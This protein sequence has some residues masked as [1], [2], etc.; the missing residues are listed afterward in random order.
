MSRG[1]GSGYDRWVAPGGVISAGS[2][3]GEGPAG[4]GTPRS[5][6]GLARMRMRAQ[7]SRRPGPAHRRTRC[8]HPRRHITIFSPEGRLFQV[9]EWRQLLAALRSS[10]N[11]QAAAIA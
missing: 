11:T 6:R 3:A 5:A 2:G 9:G 4:A 1:S 8:P 10:C 7:C